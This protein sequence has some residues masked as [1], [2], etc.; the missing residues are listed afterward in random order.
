MA[1][2]DELFTRRLGGGKRTYY[3]DVKQDTNGEKYAVISES[4][5]KE[6]DRKMRNRVMIWK[7]DFRDLFECL[8]D[9]EDFLEEEM[10]AEDARK[11]A[12][13]EADYEVGDSREPRKG[14]EYQASSRSEVG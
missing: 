8:R 3:F 13:E 1:N 5:R 6:G 4:T 14:P 7:E 12:E 11:A 2:Y 10:E 9:M